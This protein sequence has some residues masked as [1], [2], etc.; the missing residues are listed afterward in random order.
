MRSKRVSPKCRRSK[1]RGAFTLVELLVVIAIIGILVALL[2]PAIQA[3]RE[4]ARRIQCK[5]NLKNIG[6]AIHV[7]VD[8]LKVFPT[9]GSRYVTPGAAANNFGI[10]QNVE[11]GKP[12]GVDKQGLSWG[13]QILP[14]I[15]ET[16]AKSIITQTDL[17]KITVTIYACPSRRAPGTHPSAWQAGAI[18]SVLDYA[19]AQP[20]SMSTNNPAERPSRVDQSAAFTNC[21][22]FDYTKGDCVTLGNTWS[23]WTA[24]SHGKC[25]GVSG[26]TGNADFS[27]YDGV[28]VR[29][30]WVYDPGKSTPGHPSGDFCTGVSHPVKPSQITDGTSK[31]MMIAEKY[32]RNDQYDAGRNSDDAG[33]SDG[34]DADSAR[35]TAFTP[36]TDG[37]PIG[38]G[39]QAIYFA[40][41]YN[42]ARV[43]NVLHFGSA[44]TSGIN[45]VYA[46]GSVHSISYDVDHA[47]F[48]ALGTRAGDENIDITSVSN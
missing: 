27:V 37:D 42:W 32:L 25:G 14:Y 16:A 46:D 13:Y 34:W 26:G 7:H 1:R 47:V 48:N 4:S 40:D 39:P 30:P 18:V 9:G 3:A 8:A 28:I 12:L 43:Y 19:S 15:E 38:F 22:Q 2:L 20:V 23:G 33:W 6:L 17:Q 35:S 36:I 45:A 41:N 21:A 31:T 29:S 11:N 44:H 24:G 10:E 5:D